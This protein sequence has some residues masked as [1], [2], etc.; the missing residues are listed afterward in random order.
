[1]L[2]NIA[3]EVSEEVSRRLVVGAVGGRYGAPALRARPGRLRRT[4][5]P[6]AGRRSVLRPR[7]QAARARRPVPAGSGRRY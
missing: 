5:R 7:P 4:T 6:C 3:S 1:M 2:V